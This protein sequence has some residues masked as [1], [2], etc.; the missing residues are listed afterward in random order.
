M[1]TN[2]A[3]LFP[4]RCLL[5]GL[6]GTPVG[7]APLLQE[8]EQ[9]LRNPH[10]DF[11]QP[12]SQ[13]HLRAPS[14]QQQ[15]PSPAVHGVDAPALVEDYESESRQQQPPPALNLVASAMA[16]AQGPKQ[17]QLHQHERHIM[18]RPAL[19]SPLRFVAGHAGSWL[20]VSGGPLSSAPPGLPL[21][22][23]V[24][25][26]AAAASS[27]VTASSAKPRVGAL[28][29]GSSAAVPVAIVHSVPGTRAWTGAGADPLALLSTLTSSVVSA[30]QA[31]FCTIC[32]SRCRP[33]SLAT[34][35]FSG[36]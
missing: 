28:A 1:T 2:Y 15:L 29:A 36:S 19:H 21:P 14:A 8:G 17:Q 12:Q 20:D 18:S 30:D 32:P 26:L 16:Q 25:G 31:P 24:H 34:S 10:L 33:C 35:N 5:A 11:Q 22:S 23:P 27:A 6:Q 7:S 13:Q 9:Q 3:L 4:T